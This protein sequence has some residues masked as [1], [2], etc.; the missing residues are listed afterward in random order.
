MSETSQTT[1]DSQIAATLSSI[2]Y[3]RGNTQAETFTLMAKALQQQDLPTGGQWGLVWG[4][5]TY[6]SDLMYIAQGPETERGRKYAV[7]IRGTIWTVKSVLQDLKLELV[8]LP[9]NDPAAPADIKISRGISEAFNRLRAMQ[10]QN[11]NT[12]NQTALDF[13]RQQGNQNEILV[14]GHSLGGC[15]ASV[16]PLWLKTE[17]AGTGAVIKP[18]TLAGQTA[19]NRIFAD[20]FQDTFT[21]EVRFYN[22]LD[23]VPRLWNYESL[24]SIKSLYP[25][26]GPV[27]D[28]F[29]KVLVDLAMDAA[30]HNYFQPDNARALAGKVYDEKGWFEFASEVEAQHDH[31]YYMYLTG[32]P[33]RVIQGTPF[34]PGLGAGWWPPGVN[35]VY[36]ET[37]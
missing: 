12:M 14:T 27:C 21:G 4:P 1:L 7:V 36:E 33:L 37:A 6:E 30:G 23:V 20:Y 10:Q 26:P 25:Q 24:E 5:V 32:I 16:V 2:A 15:L 3:L 13:L 8:D 35:P 34:H 17:L 11:S 9:W 22:T 19:G 18:V 28:D 31:I 29:W